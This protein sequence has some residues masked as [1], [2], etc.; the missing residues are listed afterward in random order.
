[1]INSKDAGHGG[2]PHRP[3]PPHSPLQALMIH[4]FL[5]KTES[6]FQSPRG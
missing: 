1:M 4:L 5:P 3:Y 6:R 2:P